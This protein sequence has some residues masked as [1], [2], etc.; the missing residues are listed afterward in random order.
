VLTLYRSGLLV[1]LLA[2]LVVADSPFYTSS[3]LGLLVRQPPG[4][5][6]EDADGRLL[7]VEPGRGARAQ[8][9]VVTGKD[10]REAWK[11]FAASR[12]GL[13]VLEEIL[14]TSDR[15]LV[16]ARFQ[17]GGASWTGSYLL[18]PHPGGFLLAASEVRAGADAKLATWANSVIESA[19]PVR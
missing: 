3:K 11:A 8:F 1:V 9:Q 12:S 19:T 6:I 7:V 2:A 10:A 17:E 14:A 15:L 4:W 5:S 16:L 13:E 18:R